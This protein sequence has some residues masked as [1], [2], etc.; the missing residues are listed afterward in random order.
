M[1]MSDQPCEQG[2]GCRTPKV[3]RKCR[4]LRASGLKEKVSYDFSEQQ[5]YI[6]AAQLAS[7]DSCVRT[8]AI[9]KVR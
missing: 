1:R 6:E 5:R 2:F 4:H 8:L 9:P 3:H 7:Q